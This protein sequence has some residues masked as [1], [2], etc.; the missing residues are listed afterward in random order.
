MKK[1]STIFTACFLAMIS[2]STMAVNTS[3]YVID[4][5]ELNRSYHLRRVAADQS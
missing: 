1:I 4:E 2:F 3:D 5:G